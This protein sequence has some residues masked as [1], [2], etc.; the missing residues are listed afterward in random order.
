MGS[1]V[2]KD[3]E[4]NILDIASLARDYKKKKSDS[5]WNSLLDI[6]KDGVVDI[7]DL[8]LVSKHLIN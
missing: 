2:N 8:V 3:S 1:D 4:V 6:N 7:Y 5:G